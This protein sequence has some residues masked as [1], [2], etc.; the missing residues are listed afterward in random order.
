MYM[1]I[2]TGSYRFGYGYRYRCKY[3]YRYIWGAI[4]KEACG[5][6]SPFP[7]SYS[8][9]IEVNAFL[10]SRLSFGFDWWQNSITDL[11]L[12]MFLSMLGQHPASVCS[13][14][15]KLKFWIGSLCITQIIVVFN[16]TV[17]VS[18]WGSVFSPCSQC[19]LPLPKAGNYSS[20]KDIPQNF[21]TKPQAFFVFFFLINWTV[22]F[23]AKLLASNL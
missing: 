3:R 19:L 22:L 8:P 5:V 15:G 16:A 7:K 18:G 12:A 14:S 11:F 6:S 9:F 4:R 17:P 10:W 20:W 1:S 21:Y 2:G 13:S 23:L